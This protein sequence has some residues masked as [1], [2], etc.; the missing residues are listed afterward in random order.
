M[1]SRCGWSQAT[2]CGLAQS[3]C[4]P[5]GSG[6][7]DHKNRPNLG[8]Q[9]FRIM[10]KGKSCGH[11]R[12]TQ[13]HLGKA[14][15]ELCGGCNRSVGG[16]VPAMALGPAM[17][18]VVL[19]ESALALALVHHHCTMAQE[20]WHRSCRCRSRNLRRTG[21]TNQCCHRHN[22]RSLPRIY[23]NLQRLVVL[24]QVRVAQDHRWR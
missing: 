1:S 3:Q 11:N 8:F 15:L 14:V 16:E 2:C 10:D 9:Q 20:H 22:H 12:G 21:G 18:K 13:R 23:S 7:A 5:R 19:E 24:A 4:Q 17:A 6:H